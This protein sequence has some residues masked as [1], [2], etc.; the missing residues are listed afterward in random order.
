ML[1]SPFL[2]VCQSEI[3]MKRDHHA[4]KINV[5]NKNKRD[6]SG[7][8]CQFLCQYLVCGEDIGTPHGCTLHWIEQDL[9]TYVDEVMHM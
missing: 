3:M 6:C 2:S 4:Y 5:M 9:A 7:F 8:E 1:D